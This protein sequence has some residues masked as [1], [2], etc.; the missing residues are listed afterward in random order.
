[1]KY[2]HIQMYISVFMYI[3]RFESLGGHVGPYPLVDIVV[4]SWLLVIVSPVSPIPFL[5]HFFLQRK[6][7]DWGFHSHCHRIGPVG[8]WSVKSSWTKIKVVTKM[9]A[10]PPPLNWYRCGNG[11]L[12][13]S[14]FVPSATVLMR[15][16]RVGEKRAHRVHMR[17]PFLRPLKKPGVG[18]SPDP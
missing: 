1:M 13:W 14:F 3:F 5:Y 7:N 2:T 8:S 16:D 12:I 11:K 18:C 17:M 9:K 10:S 4:G 6:S 15:A